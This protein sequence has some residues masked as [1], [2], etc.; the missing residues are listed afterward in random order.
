MAK[1][2][3]SK[4]LAKHGFGKR[5]ADVSDP[6]LDP[7]GAVATLDVQETAFIEPPLEPAVASATT[8]A[9]GQT[10]SYELSGAGYD[11]P[12]TLTSGD[13]RLTVK[14]A[15]TGPFTG[16][17]IVDAGAGNDLIDVS[18]G[19]LNAMG[20]EGNDTILGSA[21][22]DTILGGAGDD[23]LQGRGGGDVLTGGAGADT[24]IFRK[25]EIQG[26]VI[27]DF[28]GASGE[29]DRIVF[30]DVAP[31]SV[32]LGGWNSSWTVNWSDGTSE[33]FTIANGWTDASNGFND[34]LFS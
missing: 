22:A 7:E 27:Q 24:F 19:S 21:S 32:M 31:G 29:G 5:A 30:E 20:G 16:T 26:A 2:S 33:T 13:D 12:L 8:V 11:L 17:V 4:S 25:G 18:T 23:E 28:S 15:A 10:Y 1:Q 34:F 9:T 6:A 3:A 14:S